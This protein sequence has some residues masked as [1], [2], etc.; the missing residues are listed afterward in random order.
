[1]R[2]QMLSPCTGDKDIQART[3]VL[4]ELLKDYRWDAKAVLVLGAL[5]TAYGGLFLPIHLA[6]C[7]PVAAS[8]ATLNQLP[9][10]RTK[11][12][13]W[14]ESLSLLVKAMV[15]VTKCII[16]FERLPFKQAKLDNNILGETLS[17][18]YLATYRVVKSA[19]ACLQQIHNFKQTQEV[20]N[21]TLLLSSRQNGKQN[22][23]KLFQ[24]Y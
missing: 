16:K 12:R 18:I 14:L 2:L 9:I 22:T 23:Q 24:A 7:D 4:F 6:F 3:M 8:I 17:N 15:A 21:S 13:P 1:M 19:L 11:F 20:Q 5:A 10:K